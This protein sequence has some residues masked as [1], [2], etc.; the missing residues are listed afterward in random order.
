[1]RRVRPLGRCPRFHNRRFGPTRL[2]R[3][4][5]FAIQ[6]PLLEL[7]LFLKIRYDAIRKI[8]GTRIRYANNN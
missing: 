8:R 6:S 4:L 1:M 7:L 2:V 3:R 5:A